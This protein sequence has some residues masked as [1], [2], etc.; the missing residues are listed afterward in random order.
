[1]P[2]YPAVRYRF[3]VPV[4]PTR[5]SHLLSLLPHAFPLRRLPPPRF[6]R[7]LL[8]PIPRLPP[9]VLI[10]CLPATPSQFAM[11]L[12]AD[13]AL[14]HIDFSRRIIQLR[15]HRLTPSMTPAQSRYCGGST[16]SSHG[17]ARGGKGKHGMSVRSVS[18]LLKMVLVGYAR[19]RTVCPFP[20]V[21]GAADTRY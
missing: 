10:S 4:L 9:P 3:A 17:S 20:Q 1:M 11:F 21:I 8:S 19:C 6:P 15:T 2:I 14:T 18:A 7:R 16:V 13:R 12:P 5:A